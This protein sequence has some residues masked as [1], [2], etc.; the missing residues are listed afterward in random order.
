MHTK[1]DYM[2]CAF[3][4]GFLYCRYDFKSGFICNMYYSSY[5]V[6]YFFILEVFSIRMNWKLTLNFTAK[7]GPMES[8]YDS[9]FDE[10]IN[11]CSLTIS[12]NHVGN[13]N[14]L[15][16]DLQNGVR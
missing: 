2:F 14:D 13:I 1:Y 3:C 7:C 6:T 12:E 10:Y 4:F 9:S 5:A 16:I 15:N 8:E 11:I